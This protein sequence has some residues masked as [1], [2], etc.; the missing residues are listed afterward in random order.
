MLSNYIHRGVFSLLLMFPGFSYGFTVQDVL[1]GYRENQSQFP[2]ISVSAVETFTFTPDGMG[3]L[4][5]REIDSLGETL[6]HDGLEAHA[7]EIANKTDKKWRS[8]EKTVHNRWDYKTDGNRYWFGMKK[9]DDPTVSFV[10]VYDELGA[11]DATHYR[12]YRPDK[13]I[14]LAGFKPEEDERNI[15]RGKNK[16]MN[17][18]YDLIRREIIDRLQDAPEN[19]EIREDQLVIQNEIKF[20]PEFGEYNVDTLTI[21]FDPDNGFLVKSIDRTVETKDVN[22]AVRT[23]KLMRLDATLDSINGYSYPKRFELDTWTP[24]NPPDGLSDIELSKW[25]NFEAEYILVNKSVYEVR[26][27]D[28]DPSFSDEDFEVAFPA[29]TKVRDTVTGTTYTV[30]GGEDIWANSLAF[31]ARAY[32][33]EHQPTNVSL[34]SDNLR[35]GQVTIQVAK[36]LESRANYLWLWLAVFLSFGVATFIVLRWKKTRHH[37]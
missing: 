17:F 16:N 10:D 12:T 22:G 34:N 4:K 29:G 28:I 7:S 6:S 13:M 2:N 30:G 32:L 36:R 33:D 8:Y 11:F 27:I 5:E 3:I 1:D 26:E 24:Q 21:E 37:G 35:N 19:V 9:V 15:Y 20:P 31:E 18:Y 25:F 23:Y 14:G